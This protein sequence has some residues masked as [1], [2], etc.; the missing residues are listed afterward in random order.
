MVAIYIDIL[1]SVFE[2]YS[3]NNDSDCSPEF[4]RIET[5]QAAA[6]AWHVLHRDRAVY[7]SGRKY[8]IFVQYAVFALPRISGKYAFGVKLVDNDDAQVRSEEII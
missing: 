2:I 6:D 4:H 1:S 7:I 8:Y 5:Y 3:R